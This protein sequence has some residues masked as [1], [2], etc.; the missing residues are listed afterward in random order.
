MTLDEWNVPQEPKI[1]GTWNLHRALQ[2]I[3]LDFFILFSSIS[4]VCGQPTQ[5]SYSA[6]SSFLDAFARYRHS[7]DLP[8]AVIDLGVV[9]NIGRLVDT[10]DRHLLET[11]LRGFKTIGE[12]EIFR[13]IEVAMMRQEPGSV[14]AGFPTSQFGVG[15]TP[16]PK[17]SP[18]HLN[19]LLHGDRRMDL[20]KPALTHAQPVHDEASRVQ[21]L[22]G[23]MSADAAFAETEEASTLVQQEVIHR[24][25]CLSSS[26]ESE[27]GIHQP[28]SQL[29]LDSLVVVEL[30]IWIQRTFHIQATVPEIMGTGHVE[31]LRQLILSR[32]KPR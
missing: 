32:V 20:L 9:G 18:H 31:G 6:A 2:G 24:L 14:S 23:A 28:F 15:L 27:V 26:N 8:A 16:P 10:E 1:A 5:A 21:R 12:K 13:A 7:L 30:R 19:S 29:G 3:D 25:S 4:G 17:D 11:T 22:F